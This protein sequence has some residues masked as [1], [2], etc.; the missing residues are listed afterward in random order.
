LKKNR[1]R[2]D[3]DSQR[4]IRMLIKINSLFYAKYREV[5]PKL[6][7][8]IDSFEKINTELDLAKRKKHALDDL[9]ASGRISQGTYENLGKELDEEVQEI[10][11]RQK[12]LAEKMTYK[13][14]ELEQQMKA[15][16]VFLA[17][18]E[19]SY[20]AA[21]I[22][23]ELH[24]Q[25]SSA[26]NLGLEATKQELNL[27]KEVIIQLIPKE[28]L[29]PPTPASTEPAEAAPT[30]T[31]IEKAP[32]VAPSV[33]IEAPVEVTPVSEETKIEPPPPA[34]MEATTESAPQENPTEETPAPFR[35]EGEETG[36]PE[37]TKES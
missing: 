10:E 9:Y 12:V 8:W 7:S 17:N 18:S 30:E 3:F 33:P 25:E 28:A 29:T 36:T 20:A 22:N 19:M 1:K 27:I 16:E 26:L 23:E 11:A 6:V 15:L 37:E 5:K 2:A 4:Y 21:E 24:T 34:P 35:G 14:N 13:L 31:A 32:E